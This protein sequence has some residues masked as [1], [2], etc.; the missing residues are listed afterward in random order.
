MWSRFTQYQ[1]IPEIL[2]AMI[3][4]TAAALLD[5]PIHISVSW[6]R[7][8]WSLPIH[9]K[10][11]KR[12]FA[13][14]PPFLGTLIQ[15]S[16]ILEDVEGDFPS[17]KG[18]SM[19][20]IYQFADKHCI[21]LAT[22]AGLAI[23]NSK[24]TVPEAL[25][26]QLEGNINPFDLSRL[27]SSLGDMIDVN[28]FYQFYQIQKKQDPDE[29][30]SEASPGSKT[31]WGVIGGMIKY[32]RFSWHQIMWEISYRNIMMLSATIPSYKSKMDKKRDNESIQDREINSGDD[33]ASFLGIKI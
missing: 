14:H 32:F 29:D 23:Q 9:K 25:I 21:S 6:H 12:I 16:E 3:K 20:K 13:I 17:P 10:N 11:A 7:P 1:Y 28:P 30:K 24:K 27:F 2:S 5:K 8:V 19:E 15:F 18:L 31:L 33:L 26:T 22:I 4:E